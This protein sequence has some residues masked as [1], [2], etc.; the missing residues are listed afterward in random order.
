VLI[1]K[2]SAIVSEY[3][4]L[5]NGHVYHIKKTRE[6]TNSD[7]I[8]CI[9]SGN[10]VQRGLPAI[11]DKWNRTRAALEC[12]ADL[13]IELPVIYA[14][15]SA[16]FF[17]FG[18]VSLINSLGVVN[19]LSFGSEIGNI[20]FIMKIAKVLLDEPFQ[21]KVNLKLYLDKGYAYPRA[22]SLALIDYLSANDELIN[23]NFIEALNSSNNILGIE[24]CKSLLRLKSTVIPSTIKREGSNY[25]DELLNDTFSSAT[26]IRKH[27]KENKSLSELSQ[28]MPF[29][30]FDLIT[31]L[32]NDGYNFVDENLM[33][34]L[35]KYK[36]YSF[37]GGLTNL[38]D[39]SEGIHNRIDEA[40]IKANDYSSLIEAV[41]TKRY[42]YTRISRILCQYFIGFDNY[43]TAEL[44]TLPCPYS[45]VLGFNKTGAKVLRQIKENSEIPIYTKLP[46]TITKTME[47]DIQATKTYSLLNTF[48]NQNSD[49]LISPIIID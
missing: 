49:Y 23:Q 27:I 9:M 33:L 2:I 15:S 5:H 37:N 41:K 21:F 25:N 48:I 12:G 7:A 42:T 17:S 13:I 45:K 44:R 31:R 46:K 3:N 22:R 47:L 11:I 18:A 39:V 14:L 1:L 16:E 29:K 28:H 19:N 20:D 8:I 10:Y 6:T 26:S 24:Y 30:S 43:N 4:P 36:N 34:P 40:I 35:I 32:Y 38:P